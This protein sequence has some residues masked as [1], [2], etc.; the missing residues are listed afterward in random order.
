MLP[1]LVLKTF[2]MGVGTASVARVGQ[3][4]QLFLSGAY[5]GLHPPLRKRSSNL[6]L[7]NGDSCQL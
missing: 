4:Y 2:L 6:Y 3:Y 5:L 7:Q 1:F